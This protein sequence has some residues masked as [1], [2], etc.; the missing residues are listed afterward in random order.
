[1]IGKLLGNRYEILEQLGGG[2][3][4]IVYKGRDTILNRLVTIKIMRPEYTSDED[5][6]RRFRREAQAVASLSHPNIVSIYDVGREEDIHYLVMEYVDGENLKTLIK[7]E[8]V[9]SPARAVQIARQ[10]SDALEHAHENNIVHRDVKPHNILITKTGRAKLTDFGI[11]REAG[12]AT[13]TH[14]DTIMGSVHYLSPEQAKGEVAGP[15]SDIYSTGAVLYEMLT[16]AVPFTGDSPIA[17][18]LKHIQEVPPAMSGLQ[19]GIPPALER[20]VMRAME[21]NPDRRF[22]G[23]GEMSRLLEDSLL[24]DTGE[25]TRFI[26]LDEDATRIIRTAELKTPAGNSRKQGKKGLGAG[27]W[28]AVVLLLGA[29]IAVAAFAFT[30]FLYVPEVNVPNVKDMKLEEAKRLLAEEGLQDSVREE[31]HPTVQAGYVIKQDPEPDKPVKKNRII[32]LTV[33]KGQDLRTVP[34]VRNKGFVDAKI[35]LAAEGFEIV[36]PYQEGYS[37]KVEKGL[38]YHQ[39]PKELSKQPRGSKITVYVSKGPNQE[40]K[41]PNLISLTQE[42]ARLKLSE[43]GLQINTDLRWETSGEYLS[44]QVIAQDPLPDAT[45][46]EGTPVKLTLSN[47]PGPPPRVVRVHVTDTIPNDGRNHVVRITVTDVRGT[48]DAYVRTHAPGDEVVERVTYWGRATIKVF[49]DDNNVWEE[50]LG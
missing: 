25:A 36:E 39:E 5:F 13:M 16:G 23:A 34:D 32:T 10:V 2:G 9:L 29:L 30:N 37:D 42:Q 41:V 49:V 14:T 17:V 22:A 19:P 18:A 26:P 7:R 3:M 35:I 4:A 8:G 47:G 24:E 20:L 11:A 28:V 48:N 40:R 38:I 1:M 31:F 6:V 43:A 46:T 50:T 12:A 21:K 45:V 44:G 27:G 33:S 15:K